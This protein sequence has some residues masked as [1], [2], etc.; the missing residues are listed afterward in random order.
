MRT[1]APRR[2]DSAHLIHLL[3]D[4]ANPSIGLVE[5]LTTAVMDLVRAGLIVPG[6]ELPPQRVLAQALS[7]SRGTVTMAYANLVERGYLEARRGSGSRIRSRAR[8][9][10]R[11]AQGRLMS[12]T[13]AAPGVVDLS[14][15]ALPASV[16][17][18]EVLGQPLPDMAA[19]YDTDGYFP[20]GV[21]AL[22]SALADHLT[23]SGLP[24]QP[25]EVVVTAGGQQGLHIAV[26]SVVQ[27]GDLCLVEEPTYR[28]ALEVLQDCSARIETV[29][30]DSGIDV[31]LVARAMTRHPAAL[32]CQTSINNPTGQTMAVDQRI[33]LADVINRNG[34]TTIEDCCSFDLT[35]S[36]QPATTL[37]GLVDPSLLICVGTFSKLFWGGLRLGWIR[38]S[39]DRIRSLTEL[40]KTVDLASSVPCQLKGIDLLAHVDQARIERQMMLNEHL[41]ATQAA[42]RE[43]FPQW[44]WRPIHGGSSLWVD[45]HTDTV[46]LVERAKR[47][48]IKLSAG[49]SFSANGGQRTMLRLPVWH[50]PDM[51]RET[52]I[53]LAHA[54]DDPARRTGGQSSRAASR[55][56][57]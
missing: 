31:R 20:Q 25:D 52:L 10:E 44:T 1:V 24:T 5:S 19:Y 3:G 2:V 8:E 56:S 51:A 6:V 39:S 18:R 14:S 42:I 30:A 50:A 27:P 55:T 35:C 11:T 48:R 15:G 45:T 21:P 47:A 43:V 12:L 37:A 23:A 33:E 9:A 16:I 13:R 32:I 40:R 36:G 49:P 38:T 53:R 28:G 7:V 4:W 57:V 29:P 26:G 34:L 17:T 22:R 46:A 54:I 41:A